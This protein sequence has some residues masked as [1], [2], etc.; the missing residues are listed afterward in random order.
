[1]WYFVG[2]WIQ[3]KV[4]IAARIKWPVIFLRAFEAFG[5]KIYLMPWRLSFVVM[6]Q[7]DTMFLSFWSFLLS[8]FFVKHIYIYIYLPF[9]SPLSNL[10]FSGSKGFSLEEFGITDLWNVKATF[11]EQAPEATTNDRSCQTAAK[12][13]QEFVLERKRR[14]F[15]TCRWQQPRSTS[16]NILTVILISLA[17]VAMC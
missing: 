16:H 12:H 5:G 8:T 15:S 7:Y 9:E 1:M 6:L 3:W 4:L 2:T 17:A 13:G 14:M 10:S 11:P